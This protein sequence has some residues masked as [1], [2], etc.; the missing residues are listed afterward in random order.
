MTSLSAPSFNEKIHCELARGL[1]ESGRLNRD[2]QGRAMAALSRFVRLA[3]A[4]YMGETVERRLKALARAL[5]LEPK[6]K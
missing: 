6:L 4:P 2:G 5:D 1:T 3:R